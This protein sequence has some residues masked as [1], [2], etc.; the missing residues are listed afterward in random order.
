MKN[1]AI[2]GIMAGALALSACD[3]DNDTTYVNDYRDYVVGV[4]NERDRWDSDTAYWIDADTRYDSLHSSVTT[5]RDE[6]D[7]NSQRQVDSLDNVWKSYKSEYETNRQKKAAE[8]D[9]LQINDRIRI[10][11]FPA[12]STAALTE[13]TAA[14]IRSYYEQ[15]VNT[16][17][18]NS[19][20]YTSA[21]WDAIDAWYEKLDERKNDLE[22]DMTAADRNAISALKIKYKSIHVPN[23][24]D[25]KVEEKMDQK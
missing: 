2:A 6:L 11:L 10:S 15:L 17:G 12:G 3:D 8:A 22:K 9:A 13:V 16:A 25:S 21:E 24:A 4:G 7:E 20:K 5:R 1:L 23:R 14:N 19:E 18:T